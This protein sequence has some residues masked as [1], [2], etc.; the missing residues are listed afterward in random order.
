MGAAPDWI[1]KPYAGVGPLRFGMTPEEAEAVIGPHETRRNDGDARGRQLE[2]SFTEFRKGT[3][4]PVLSYVS[5]K[6]KLIDFMK[7]AKTLALGDLVLF[8]Q[9]RQ[10]IIDALLD[11][12]TNVF[13]TFEGYQ[14]LDYGITMLSAENARGSVQSGHWNIGVFDAGYFDRNIRD[15]LDEDMGRFVKG[16]FA[17]TPSA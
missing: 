13:E 11:G 9:G 5:G 14:F 7:G 8:G 3:N 17:E 15:S 10:A 1:I 6:L 16:G 12:S 4:I 2:G